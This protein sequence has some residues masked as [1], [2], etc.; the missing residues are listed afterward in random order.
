MAKHK[1]QNNSYKKIILILLSII[2]INTIIL[3]VRIKIDEDRENE[4]Q[5]EVSNVLDTIDVPDTEVT[6]VVTER[7]LKVKELKQENNDIVGWIEVDG[8]NIKY[9][10]LQGKDNDYYLKHNYKYEY[11]STGSIFLD[12]DYDFS[13]PSSN[14]LIYGHRNKV[15]LM[16]DELIK[17]KDEDFYKEHKKI[18]FTTIEEDA[19]FEI[20]AAFYSRVYYTDEKDVFRYYYFVNAKNE[21]EYNEFVNNSKKASLYDTGV[22][23]IYG[24]QL[25]TLSTCDYNQENGRFAVVAKKIK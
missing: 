1:K 2:L 13:I 19:E 12:K 10:V 6:A 11:I 7:M 4:S 25:M 20:M 17:Y 23:A 16:F 18:R 24:E 21:K 8:T 3:I 5:R 15:G 9:P 22:T 14:L